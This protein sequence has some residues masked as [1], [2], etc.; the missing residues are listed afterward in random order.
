M[1]DASYQSNLISVIV[2]I[3]NE[4]IIIE[5]VLNSLKEQ[6]LP[7]S[8][9]LEIILIDGLSDDRTLDIINEFKKANLDLNIKI[10]TNSKKHIPYALNMGIKESS[11]FYICE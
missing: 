2:P 3:R 9:E 11:G 8:I 4:E 10:L 6:S 1:N 7:K 5:K